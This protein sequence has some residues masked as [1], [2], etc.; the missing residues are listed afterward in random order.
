M[1]VRISRTYLQVPAFVK[2][3]FQ[4]VIMAGSGWLS[5]HCTGTLECDFIMIFQYHAAPLAC[6]SLCPHIFLISTASGTRIMHSVEFAPLLCH[7]SCVFLFFHPSR[8]GTGISNFWGYKVR[9]TLPLTV[10]LQGFQPIRFVNRPG[11]ERPHF[12]LTPR[13]P[14]YEFVSILVFLVAGNS[15][16]FT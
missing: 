3:Q 14:P 16:L 6:G 9:R 15:A 10:P 7:I 2:C 12:L 5:F 11:M 8:S 4:L 13:L 1:S